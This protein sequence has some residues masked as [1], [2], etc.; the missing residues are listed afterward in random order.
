MQAEALFV[1][2][3]LYASRDA[4]SPNEADANRTSDVRQAIRDGRT[5]IV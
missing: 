3:Y 4:I 2:C 1:G 5:L